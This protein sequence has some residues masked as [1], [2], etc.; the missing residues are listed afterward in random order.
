MQIPRIDTSNAA[1]LLDKVV[2]LGKEIVGSVTG[3]DRLTKSGQVQQKKGT[4]RIEVVRAQA[5]AA[6]H[7]TR[8]TAAERAQK[9]TQQSKEEVTR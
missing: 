4:E 1:G 7:D 5:Q 9:R 3:R 2:G 8:A 6:A